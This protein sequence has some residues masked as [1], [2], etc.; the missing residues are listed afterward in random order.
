MRIL[1]VLMLLLV[2]GL[3][4]AACEAI[5]NIFQAGVWTGVVLVAVLLAGVAFL[6]TKLRT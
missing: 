3:T 4:T 6:A 5:L 2:A 1:L